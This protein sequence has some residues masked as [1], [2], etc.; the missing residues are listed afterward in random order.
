MLYVG[1]YADNLAPA[2]R[3]P[4]ADALADRVF[5]REVSAR[6]RLA[7]DDDFGRVLVIAFGE[8]ASRDEPHA[9]R[10]DIVLAHGTDPCHRPLIGLRRGTAFDEKPG[11]RVTAREP[12]RGNRPRRLHPRH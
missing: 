2:L 9:H 11:V 6:R 3:A 5:V 12:K 7:D 1:R 10:A 4:I 8:L